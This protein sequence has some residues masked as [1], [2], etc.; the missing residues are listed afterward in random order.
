MNIESIKTLQEKLSEL[1]G[2][3]GYEEDVSKFILTL[4][5]EEQ[6]ADKAWIDQLGNVLAVVNGEQNEDRIL[7]DAHI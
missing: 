4:I 5:K 7:L 2:V 6:L 1:I 3:S